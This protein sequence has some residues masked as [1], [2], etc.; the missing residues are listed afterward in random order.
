MRIFILL[1]FNAFILREACGFTD[2]TDMQ[3]LLEFK[4]QVS[5]DKRVLL[6]SWNHSV[7][8]CNWNKVTCGHKH[9]RVT[10]LDLGG[11]LL[12]GVISP[13]IGNLS[14]LISLDLSNNSFGGT[15]PQEVGKLFRLEYLYMSSNVLR[16]GMPTSL[17]NCSRLLDLGGGVPSELGSLKKLVVLDIGRNNLGKLLHL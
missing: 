15:I 16:R 6:S 10:G 17:S 8:L 14:F 12:G 11:L 9:K 1:S 13:S 2:E 4:S 7:P 3:A 5:Q